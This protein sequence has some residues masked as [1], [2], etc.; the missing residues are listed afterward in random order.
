MQ[1]C[2]KC[3]SIMIIKED[4]K[5]KVKMLACRKCRYRTKAKGVIAIKEK[6]Q[7]RPMDEVVIVEK[8]AEALPKIKIIC[9]S[10]GNQEAY[11]WVQQTRSAD[12]APT[13]FY[14]CTKCG[15]TW[16]EYG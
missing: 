4:K 11:W 5:K 6:V 7:K 14:R 12:E 16:R 15:H 10:C 13:T 1:F 9:P 8:Q 2:P 3:G